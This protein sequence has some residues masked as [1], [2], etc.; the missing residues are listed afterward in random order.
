[1]ISLCMPQSTGSVAKCSD[2]EPIVPI[3]V[4]Q[5]SSFLALWPVPFVPHVLKPAGGRGASVSG[6]A[7]LTNQLQC[8]W[9]DPA[10]ALKNTDKQL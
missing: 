10:C 5:G 8:C 4:L 9:F 1:M 2:F 7:D 3:L 6:C